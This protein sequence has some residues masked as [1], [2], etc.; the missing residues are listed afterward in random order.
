MGLMAEEHIH[1]CTGPDQRCPCGYVFR[2]PRYCVSIEVS[3]GKET[4]VEKGFNCDAL[5]VVISALRDAANRLERI[6][7]G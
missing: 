3:D 6:S 4:L 2:V 1:D 5:S 7:W